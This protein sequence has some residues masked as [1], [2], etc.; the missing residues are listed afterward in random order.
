MRGSFSP[1]L[2]FLCL[3]ALLAASP[4]GG[5]G[6]LREDPVPCAHARGRL[7]ARSGEGDQPG[8]REWR[9]G[10]YE[11]TG[12]LDFAA[13]RF[14]GHLTAHLIPR[15]EFGGA[16]SLVLD[17]LATLVVSDV[18]VDGVPATWRRRDEF[19]IVVAT[20]G[21]PA[22]VPVRVEVLY[23]A[24]PNFEG[25]FIP[26][27][28]PGYY[29][30]GAIA[31]SCQTMTETQYAG[32]WWPCID[33]LTHP[34]D[35]VALAVTVPDTMM[36]AANGVLEA[37]ETPEPGK[38]TYRWRERH[39]IATYLVG[40][41]VTNF[42]DDY[43][44]EGLHPPGAGWPWEETYT[45]ASDGTTM[46]LQY[47]IWPKHRE[48]AVPMLSQIPSML[49]CYCEKFGDY[50]FKD[51]KYG[52]AEF[53]FG[54]GMEHQTCSFIG[55][56]VIASPDTL[57]YVQ[58]HELSHQWFGDHVSPATWEDIWLNEGFATYSEAIFYEWAGR[59]TA[60]EYMR[61]RRWRQ[62][63][64]GSVY[65]PDVTF[66]TTSYYKGGWT[67]HMLRQLV[68]DAA[69]FGILEYW[70]QD[71]PAAAGNGIGST[72][73]F[74]A[75]A[76]LVSGR[77]LDGFFQRWVYGTG[78]PEYYYEWT[79]TEEAGGQ[80]LVDLEL[81]QTQAGALFPD[82]L[83]IGLYTAGGDSVIHR[84][85]P[86]QA[87]QSYAWTLAAE[88]TAVALDPHHRLLHLAVEGRPG[89]APLSLAAPYPN[90]FGHAAGTTI[91]L[92]HRTEGSVTVTLF[93][94]RGR[95]VRTLLDEPRGYGPVFL[96]WDGRDDGGHVLAYGVYLLRAE[97]AG[98]VE[99][100]KIVFLPVD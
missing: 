82:S 86:D 81:R 58:P 95:R 63:F 45:F 92:A 19:C 77:D 26:F 94:V 74:Q 90:P 91:E 55:A 51:E 42:A 88:P 38:R 99:A 79:A 68:G 18:S 70:A 37:I 89:D 15:A 20:P 21:A 36:V 1:P 34:A 24:A 50:P 84:V 65:A 30:N 47:F 2:L 33:R 67:L 10:F 72:A 25:E 4:A 73:D 6:K 39:R 98:H 97:A 96:N 16:D 13:E 11:I 56:S 64:G 69:F 14:L 7:A 43:Q 35:S 53:S 78:R 52:V 76:E 48:G 22:E 12:E 85:C 17:A 27:Y 66:G 28:F 32:A 29:W 3:A 23:E 9:A 60:G 54:G 49:D 80:W 46:P 41:A 71:S 44:P 87:V 8:Q 93:D 5:D 62:S 83:D 100:R 61:S 75:A 57:H 31:A 40:M 59:Y